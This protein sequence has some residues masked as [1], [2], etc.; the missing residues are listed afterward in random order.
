MNN[1]T[2]DIVSIRI[3]ETK[4]NLAAIVG[5][6]TWFD[7][8]LSEI[9][10]SEDCA[11]HCEIIRKLY[12]LYLNK[13]EAQLDPYLLNTFNIF[14]QTKQKIYINLPLNDNKDFLSLLFESYD[15]RRDIIIHMMKRRL[16]IAIRIF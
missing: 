2:L 15:W 1:N 9:I 11:K 4:R 16:K 14:R 10:A 6:I 3:I 5:A 7:M 13:S 12:K 8:V